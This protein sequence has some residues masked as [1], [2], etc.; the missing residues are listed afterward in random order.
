MESEPLL[1]VPKAAAYLKL[2][3]ETVR[4]MAREGALPA[5]KVGRSWRFK[6]RALNDWVERHGA[7]SFQGQHILCVDDDEDQLAFLRAVLT[8]EGHSVAITTDTQKSLAMIE[9]RRPD[10]IV[11]DLSMPGMNGVELL[12]RIHESWPDI[13]ITILTAFPD[14]ELLRQAIRI[15]PLTLLAKPLRIRHLLDTLAQ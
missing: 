8:R 10:R 6:A 15:C 13:P 11:L 9:K 5:R 4:R 14:G 12:R 3:A 1:D 2:H 7:A